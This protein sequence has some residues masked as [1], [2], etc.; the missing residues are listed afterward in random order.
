MLLKNPFSFYN[1]FMK[2]FKVS[3]QETG[4]AI[5]KYVSALF[6][7]VPKSR[8]EKMF[9]NKDISINAKRTND[10]KIAI[11]TGDTIIIYGIDAN[12]KA[13]TYQ[14]TKPNLQIIYEDDNILVVCKKVGL[15]TTGNA[16]SLDNDVWSYLDFKQT[17][18]F[19][20]SSIGRLD[21]VTSGLVIYGKNYQAL[22][23]LKSKQRQ[24]VKI[25]AFK[26]DL[27]FSITTTFRI[28]HDEK[29][30]KQKHDLKGKRTKT[31]FKVTKTQKTAQIITGKK[32]Q[33]R[34][35]LATL[36]YP[37]YGDTKY[38]GQEA[39]RVFLH[40]QMIRL[41]ALESDLKYLNNLQLISKPNW[42]T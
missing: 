26:S 37:I 6:K 32:H 33:I 13:L 15:V 7:D 8:I 29:H 31:I 28:S 19:I 9:R 18:S 39:K 25:Y 41:K 14:K 5:F 38:G 27:P 2:V 35:S 23:Q 21:K 36:G 12:L 11:K 34:V 4:R 24:W 16:L 17:D 40:C 30:R 10:K 22:R 42:S 1:F 3:S 20:P